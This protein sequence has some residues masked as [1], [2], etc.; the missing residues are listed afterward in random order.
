MA[1]TTIDRQWELERILE[2]YQRR[3]AE[4]ERQVA[5]LTSRV[6]SL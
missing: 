3:I 4:L 2:D 1:R 6:N 5:A